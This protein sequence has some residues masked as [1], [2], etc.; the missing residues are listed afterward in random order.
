M[1]QAPA[2]ELLDLRQQDNAWRLAKA[3]VFSAKATLV[4]HV[5]GSAL[6]V[7]VMLDTAKS[8]GTAFS[9]LLVSDGGERNG[10]GCVGNTAVTVDWSDPAA[11]TL[12]V[13]LLAWRC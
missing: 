10:K 1:H 4:P 13:P 11:G 12:K 5:S 3:P 7:E 2:P 6:N 9:V 8:E